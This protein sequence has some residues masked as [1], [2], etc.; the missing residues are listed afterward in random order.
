LPSPITLPKRRKRRESALP[1]F[2][3]GLVK[4]VEPA[5]RGRN[6]KA[7]KWANSNM[8]TNSALLFEF[9]LFPPWN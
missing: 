1:D 7:R 5:K 9:S 6:A 3:N 8:S 4:P 2:V